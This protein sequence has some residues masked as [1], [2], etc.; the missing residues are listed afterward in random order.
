MIPIIAGFLAG[1]DDLF[2]LFTKSDIMILIP[3][4]V[5]SS[6]VAT[7]TSCSSFWLDL[8]LLTLKTNP[9]ELKH[10]TSVIDPGTWFIPELPLSWLQ[11]YIKTIAHFKLIDV[12]YQI[13]SV[14]IYAVCEIYLI[15]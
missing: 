1:I 13:F 10:L 6:D 7:Y 12:V 15:F 14:P 5:N 3:R 4:E 2:L 9:M 11:W 8:L